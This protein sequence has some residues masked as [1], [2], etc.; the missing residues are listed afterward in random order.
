MET[1]DSSLT[2]SSWPSGQGAGSL[3]ADMGR[4]SSNV[5]PQARQR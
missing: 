3:D 2:V 4:D 1:V 5:E